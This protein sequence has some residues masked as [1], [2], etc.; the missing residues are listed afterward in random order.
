MTI[1]LYSVVLN[2]HQMPVADALF[3][4]LGNNFNFV[5]LEKPS[6]S[7]LKGGDTYRDRSYLI[8]SWENEHSYAI[9][10]QL[11]ISSDVCI[12][13]SNGITIFQIVRLKQNKLSFE[14]GEHWLKRGWINIFSPS[15][16]KWLINYFFRGWYRKQLFH[17]CCS[18]YASNDNKKLFTYRNK[19]FKW[20]YF[21]DLKKIE[22]EKVI[23]QSASSVISIM[24]CSRFISWKHPETPILLAK[25]LKDL[26]LDFEMDIFGEGPLLEKTK[27]M[28]NHL[29]LSG[30]VSFKGN[31]SNSEVQIAMQKHDIFLF[32]SDRNEGWGVVANEAMNNGC[33]VVAGHLI[34]CAPYLIKNGDTGM[35][36]QNNNIDDLL[37]KIIYLIENPN[38]IKKIAISAN[39][40]INTTWSSD[41]AV[42][43]LL[44]LVTDLLSNNVPRKQEGPCSQ[45]EIIKNNWY[46]C[47]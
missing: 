45:A 15:L 31:V 21:P 4:H 29:G 41:N 16:I 1:T 27:K 47:Q 40:Y 13:A 25:K 17:L 6:K 18:A 7:T 12:F 3:R 34:G 22:I 11:A 10:M 39:H 19:C 24:W 37:N 44:L 30:N 36:Y 42:H 35:I 9:A 20:G 32:T 38:I 5:E 33:V 14:M 28:A 26:S 43:N 46:L 23:D 8:Q 2:H